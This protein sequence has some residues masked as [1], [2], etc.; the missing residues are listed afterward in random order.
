MNT[1]KAE[2]EFAESSRTETLPADLDAEDVAPTPSEVA[3]TP[4][5]EDGWLVKDKRTPG[6]TQ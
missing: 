2:R 1:E 3:D 6:D 5:S 4:A